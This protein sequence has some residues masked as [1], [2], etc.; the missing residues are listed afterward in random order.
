MSDEINGDPEISA[1]DGDVIHI[2]ESAQK[3][4]DKILFS[5]IE[6]GTPLSI[7]IPGMDCRFKS[8]LL[9]L[10][11]DQF[12]IIKLPTAPGINQRLEQ[13][14]NIVVR[15][16]SNGS[17]IGLLSSIIQIHFEPIGVC[18][19][20]FPL[21]AERINLRK[22]K[23]V[24]CFFPTIV[25]IKGFEFRGALL[26]MSI[27]GCRFFVDESQSG[28][29]RL[30]S[31]EKGDEISLRIE[32]FGSAAISGHVANIEFGGGLYSIGIRFS[33][34][35]GELRAKIEEILSMACRVLS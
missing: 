16:V 17:I 28:L 33:S 27:A 11:P 26:D 9:G 4:G 31:V 25:N 7:E 22:D 15:F 21:H 13:G 19:L 10:E 29:N 24:Q 12:L 18:F 32:A 3:K 1:N 14:G 5:G 20:T 34:I 6:V 8:R 23:R 2:E 35:P 30:A